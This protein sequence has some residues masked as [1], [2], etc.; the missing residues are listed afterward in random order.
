MARPSRGSTRITRTSTNPNET[1]GVE[2]GSSAVLYRSNPTDGNG[3]SQEE[4]ERTESRRDRQKNGGKNILTQT[5]A[6][7]SK[8]RWTQMNTDPSPLP[9]APRRG[10]IPLST[11]RRRSGVALPTASPGR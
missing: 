9:K 10:R 7:Q 2:N 5:A 6:D 3:I 4:A 8:H 11:H 1:E